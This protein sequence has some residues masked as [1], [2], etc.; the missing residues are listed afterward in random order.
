MACP[1]CSHT[2]QGLGYG[3][4]HCPRCGTMKGEDAVTVPALVAR[5][6]IFKENAEDGRGLSPFS[7]HLWHKLGIDESISWER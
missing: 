3:I 4:F 6:K 7:E 1:T 2:M 5:C